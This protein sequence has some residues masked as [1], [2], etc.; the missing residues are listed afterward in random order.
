M[1]TSKSTVLL[2]HLRSETARM[3]GAAGRR[4]E[5]A[6]GVRELRVPLEIDGALWSAVVE[7]IA[8]RSLDLIVD[9]EAISDVTEDADGRI[10]YQPDNAAMQSF[11]G[12]VVPAD[13]L[14]GQ[15]V[16][17]NFELS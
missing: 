3:G 2:D 7:R 10:H 9:R 11:T 15:R 16:R 13:T 12:R 1:D 8:E 4:A 6:A 5:D 17:L 14:A